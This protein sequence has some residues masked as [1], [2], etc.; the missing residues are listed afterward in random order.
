VIYNDISAQ[1]TACTYTDGE[2]A[3]L[4]TDDDAAD[5]SGSD[6]SASERA[7]DDALDKPTFK[8]DEDE[9]DKSLDVDDKQ[10]DDSTTS[11]TH[12]FD[13]EHSINHHCHKHFSCGLNNVNYCKDHRQWV[14]VNSNIININNSICPAP[15]AELLR[16]WEVSW[17]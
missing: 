9:E 16:C 14:T 15:F 2:A 8:I 17:A 6:T 13:I 1:Y 10:V 7:S 4:S 11:D 3:L 12:G 5:S